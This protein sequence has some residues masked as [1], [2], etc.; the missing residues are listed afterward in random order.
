MAAYDDGACMKN[1][2]PFLLK[3]HRNNEAMVRIFNNISSRIWI[4]DDRNL[5]GAAA[6]AIS[7]NTREMKPVIAVVGIDERGHGSVLIMPDSCFVTFNSSV[8]Y[9]TRINDTKV[10]GC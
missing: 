1:L 10:H 5:L 4:R 3:S 9:T 6:E 7:T 8:F 2:I